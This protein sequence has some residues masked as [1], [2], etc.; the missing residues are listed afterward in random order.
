MRPTDEDQPGFRRPNLMSASRRTSGE[1]NILAMLDGLGSRPRGRRTRLWYGAGGVLACALA[2]MLAWMV[3]EPALEARPRP[4]ALALEL[5]APAATAPASAS[6]S[7]SAASGGATIVNLPAVSSADAG[8]ALAL[9][10]AVPAQNHAVANAPAHVP[11]H[12]TAPKTAATHPPLARPGV[13]IA[14]PAPHRI[15]KR[16]AAAGRRASAP[17]PVD[18]DVALISAII[19]HATNG[20]TGGTGGDDGACGDKPCG[21]RTPPRP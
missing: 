12:A 4:A 8:P 7:A 20:R 14:R 2:G 17:A 11:D 3:R 13:A 5:P 15:A 16:L 18:T 9:P 6:A 21:P 1:V 19:Q 10:Q